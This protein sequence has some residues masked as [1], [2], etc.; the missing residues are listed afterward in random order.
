MRIL[1]IGTGSGAILLALLSELETAQGVATDISPAALDVARRNAQRHGLAARARFVETSWTDG[2]EGAFDL[3]VSNPP[4][5]ET[6]VIAA[7]DPEVR[8]HEPHLALDGGPDGLGPYPHLFSEAKRLLVPGGKGVF[9]IGHD[10][11]G[12]ALELARAAGARAEI[13]L[14]LA[15]R[16]RAVVFGF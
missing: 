10:Q 13:R 1:D 7:L 4:Y 14:D 3:V 9:E 11:G 8:D 5:I 2:V 16:D 12:R 15:G 6:G